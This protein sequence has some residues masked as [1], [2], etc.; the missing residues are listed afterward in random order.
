MSEKNKRFF[1]KAAI[2][3]GIILLIICLINM[4]DIRQ[5]FSIFIGI[6]YI[7]KAIGITSIIGFLYDKFIWKI[8]PTREYPVFRNAYEGIIKTNYEGKDLQIKIGVT[9][10]QTFFS[11]KITL[12][13]EES[14]SNAITYKFMEQNGEDVLIFTYLNIPK[15]EFREK[16]DIHYGTSVLTIN[17]DKSLDGFYYTDRKTRGDIILKPIDEI[18]K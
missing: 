2:T 9:I 10:K 7:T 6:G 1:K 5:N 11:L 18:N 3:F 13:T 4:E 16:S 14:K 8:D 12:K 17:N 15:A